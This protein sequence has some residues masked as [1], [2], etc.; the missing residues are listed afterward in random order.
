MLF[1]LER[2][3]TCDVYRAG[4]GVH[5]AWL[6]RRAPYG[7]WWQRLA[8]RFNRRHRDVLEIEQHLLGGGGTDR[9]IANSHLV[10]AEIEEHFGFPGEQIH[11]IHNGV[12]H[13]DAVPGA[14]AAVRRELGLSDSEYVIL[15][16]GSGWERKGLRYAVKA[17]NAARLRDATLLVAGR[18]NRG[19]IPRSKQVRYLGPRE[20]VPLLLAA[21]DLFVL[22]T[23]YDPFSN[24][25]LE[26]AA[27]AKPV[28]TTR[29][30]GFAEIM[31]PGVHGEVLAE[32]SDVEALAR[33]IT[34]WAP[35]ERRAEAALGLRELGARFS[36]EEN[37]R[38]SLAILSEAA[39]GRSAR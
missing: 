38:Q 25:C 33:A 37:V 39:A 34:E 20:D 8:R 4:D 22:P 10:K 24:A 32:P 18:G 16:V 13:A 1:S 17:M 6:Q 3:W 2:V 12:P 30:N 9:V 31:E 23:I 15:F 14:R 27:A 36:V 28:V 11:V 5:A 19:S 26:A 29:H 21:S 35:R 7:P